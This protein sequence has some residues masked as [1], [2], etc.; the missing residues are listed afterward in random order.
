[1]K[2]RR[3]LKHSRRF[4]CVSFFVAGSSQDMS[5]MLK[6][7]LK[8][9]LLSKAANSRGQFASKSTHGTSKDEDCE[10]SK[11]KTANTGQQQWNVLQSCGGFSHNTLLCAAN[12]LLRASDYSNFT[13]PGHYRKLAC[14]VQDLTPRSP[15]PACH[16]ERATEPGWRRSLVDVVS[17]SLQSLP[18]GRALGRRRSLNLV[19]V[20]SKRGRLQTVRGWSNAAD[21]TPRALGFYFTGPDDDVQCVFCLGVLKGRDVQVPPGLL[22]PACRRRRQLPYCPFVRDFDVQNIADGNEE[23]ELRDSRSE[24]R[25]SDNELRVSFAMYQ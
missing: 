19:S 9:Y 22:C 2:E 11:I 4:W 23:H 3:T 18:V 15:A 25:H 24:D 6:L 14:S 12:H 17:L 1:M 8:R 13:L 20:L 7:V 16:F 10:D 5:A 21:I